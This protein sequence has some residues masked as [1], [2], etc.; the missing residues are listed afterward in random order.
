MGLKRRVALDVGEKGRLLHALDGELE[1]EAP[2]RVLVAPKVQRRRGELC[3]ES[4]VIELGPVVSVGVR[5]E[6]L[7]W[8]AE[9]IVEVESVGDGRKAARGACLDVE[10]LRVSYRVED[11]GEEALEELDDRDEEHGLDREAGWADRNE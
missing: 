7:G 1:C 6:T 3:M 9:R 5:R 11:E 10:R 4:W 8:E 2:G